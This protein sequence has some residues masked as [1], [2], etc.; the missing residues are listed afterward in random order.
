MLCDS[1][2]TRKHL[3]CVT[4]DVM[5]NS[6]G[7]VHRGV[8]NESATAEARCANCAD[9]PLDYIV[10]LINSQFGYQSY[11]LLAKTAPTSLINGDAVIQV[12]CNVLPLEGGMCLLA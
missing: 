12:A 3:L 9:P 2:R 4:K 5:L 6:T 7:K 8:G 1:Y 10:R 11:I